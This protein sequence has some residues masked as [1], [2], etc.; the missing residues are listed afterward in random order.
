MASASLVGSPLK[1]KLYLS[2][3]NL[4][5]PMPRLLL[6]KAQGWNDQ[7]VLANLASSSIR[8]KMVRWIA[9]FIR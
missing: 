4:T 8:V 3:P 7:F 5:L 1:Q 2:F 9:L 6:S